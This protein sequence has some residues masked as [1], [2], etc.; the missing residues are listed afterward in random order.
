[1][2]EA[3]P[4]LLVDNV[5]QTSRTI[6]VTVSKKVSFSLEFKKGIRTKKPLSVKNKREI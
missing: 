4:F 2:P 6:L 3:A 5:S 1:M